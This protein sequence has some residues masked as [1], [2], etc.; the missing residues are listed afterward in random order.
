[1]YL[2]TVATPPLFGHIGVL[3]PVNPGT[4]PPHQAKNVPRLLLTMDGTVSSAFLI[5]IVVNHQCYIHLLLF[6]S[7]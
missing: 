7:A 6:L 1:M 3:A 2:K 5:L 4:P